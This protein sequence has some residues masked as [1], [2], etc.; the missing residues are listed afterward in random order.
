MHK[1]DYVIQKELDVYVNCIMVGENKAPDAHL[2]FFW[3]YFMFGWFLK[4][5]LKDHELQEKYV[6]NSGLD[7]TIAR[8]CGFIDGEKTGQ[9][10]HGFNYDLKKM[11]L[12]I[13]R[14]DVAD[15]LLKQLNSSEYLF[16]TPG[17]SC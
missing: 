7:W 15:F 14:S 13:R 5:V 11:K 2:H 1:V 4:D 9:Y 3:K 12:K 6:R 10:E 17:V 16:K 8:P